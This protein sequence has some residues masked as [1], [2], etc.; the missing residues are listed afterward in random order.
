MGEDWQKVA[1]TQVK[2]AEVL[3][4]RMDPPQLE[5]GE[6]LLLDVLEA[7]LDNLGE[8]DASVADLR[9]VLGACYWQQGK[10]KEAAN[11]FRQ[12]W[13]VRK[14][15]LGPDHP[16]TLFAQGYYTRMGH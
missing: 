3:I 13:E 5:E 8:D 16:D 9:W 1:N 2:L 10:R 6:A 15:V 12:C 7:R 11:E 4:E 14:K